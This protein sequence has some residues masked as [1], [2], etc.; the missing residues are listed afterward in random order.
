MN[1]IEMLRAKEALFKMIAQYCIPTKLFDDSDE[2]YIYNY[3]ESALESTFNVLGID[4]NYI[5]L[6]D[7][8]KMW[9]NNNR[10]IW[11]INIPNEPFNGVDAN[12][13]YNVFKESYENH[14]KWL[15]LEE[16]D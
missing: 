14:Q 1:N 16:E 4:E 7:F 9:E 11:A 2:L 6:M 13:Y 15:D 10:A 3:C 12:V 5:T 8:C